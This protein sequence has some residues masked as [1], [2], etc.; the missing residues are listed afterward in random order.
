ML[1]YVECPRD[2]WQGLSQ[3]IP[4]EEKTRYIQNL[5][6][7]GFLQLDMGSF[8]SSKAVP[9]LADTE[10]VLAKLRPPEHADLLCIIANEKGL[11]RALAAK[12][13]TSVA[14]P[15]SVN[16]TFQRRNT[17]RSLEESWSL[18]KTLL[19]EKGR[20]ELVIHI[21]MGFGN[22]Y[23]EPWQASD[24]ANAVE[25]LRDMG[26][27]QIALADTVG[28]ATPERLKNVLENIEHPERVGLH[29]HA[30]PNAWQEQ[31]EVALHYG[32]TWFEGALA[33][34]G[35]CPFADDALVGNLPTEKVLAWFASR[36]LKIPVPVEKVER[37]R[38]EAAR[39]AKAYQ[40]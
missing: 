8:V 1:R 40:G 19:N 38:L 9:Q 27:R 15:L 11:E 33:G 16:D 32:I 21:S 4:T 7:A 25:K 30:R 39:I 29:L 36:G 23:S 3:F 18:V 2:S 34:V 5:L 6:D 22:P 10:E 17:N 28:T 26:I 13:I 35:G 12:N 37:L 14:Y 20:L 31:L 24:T